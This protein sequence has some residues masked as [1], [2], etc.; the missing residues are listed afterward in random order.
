MT[1]NATEL[2]LE[3]PTAIGSR[4]LLRVSLSVGSSQRRTIGGDTGLVAF[5]KVVLDSGEG[6]VRIRP[7]QQY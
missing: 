7:P 3:A 4:I 1:E 2:P 5:F 6:V